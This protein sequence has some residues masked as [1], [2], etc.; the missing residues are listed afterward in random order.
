MPVFSHQLV[1]SAADESTPGVS[2]LEQV[3][4]KLIAAILSSGDVS[5]ISQMVS[6]SSSSVKSPFGSPGRL[7]TLSQTVYLLNTVHRLVAESRQVTQR[8]LFYR[9]LSEVHAPRFADQ[10]VLN[11]ALLSLMDTV[12]CDRH[13]LGVFTT[14]RGLVASDPRFET[15]CLDEF[16]EFLAD[17]SDHP[18]GLSI[19]ESL[20]SMRTLQTE[21]EWI[22]VVE[23]DTVFQS[24]LACGEFFQHNPCILVTAR[25]FPDNITIRFLQ[26]LV[27]V[28]AG[29]LP[30]LYL[31]DLDPH[32]ICIFLTFRKAVPCMRWIGLR[33]ADVMN[34]DLHALMGIKLKPADVALLNGLLENPATPECVKEDLCKMEARGL[35]FEVECLHS[36]GEY[37]LAK[38]WLPSKVVGQLR[39]S[40]ETP[41]RL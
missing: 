5:Q 20:T 6:R 18:D 23:K 1:H 36:A 39:N 40:P 15:L 30:L 38:R 11:R 22:L 41:P 17:I 32:G 4:V 14:A 3:L 25:G 37:H 33:F 16:S 10:T 26:R 31:G 35:K 12:G 24:L 9:S 27:A 21:A 34:L 13:S 2:L 29:T 7:R 19:S 28:T 8:E